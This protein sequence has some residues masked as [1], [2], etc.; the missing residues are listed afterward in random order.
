MGRSDIP[1]QLCSRA[2]TLAIPS[3]IY[4][5]RSGAEAIRRLETANQTRGGPQQWIHTLPLVPK[6]SIL[7]LPESD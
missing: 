5:G 7:M 3:H 6:E 4:I 2:Q 1:R